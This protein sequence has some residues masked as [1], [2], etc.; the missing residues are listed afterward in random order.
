M[1]EKFQILNFLT[2]IIFFG[3]FN[4]HQILGQNDSDDQIFLNST[5]S[6]TR[7]A[8]DIGNFFMFMKII[9]TLL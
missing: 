9:C 1:M 3:A 7:K 2:L 5:E 6:Q 8:I 4:I